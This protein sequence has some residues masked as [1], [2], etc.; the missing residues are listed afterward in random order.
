MLKL[1]TQSLDTGNNHMA[2]SKDKSTI[3]TTN[4]DNASYTFSAADFGYENIR[5]SLFECVTII[6]LPRAGTLTLNNVNVACNQK[7]AM[8]DIAQL[9]FN[10]TTDANAEP[11]YADYSFVY[12]KN[13]V[14]YTTVNIISLAVNRIKN[15]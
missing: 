10:P 7:I 12:E 8:V 3:C 9:V 14:L 1:K 5:D 11:C 2:S 13:N 4:Q 15:A 6:N